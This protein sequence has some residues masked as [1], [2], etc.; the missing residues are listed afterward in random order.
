[1]ASYTAGQFIAA[2][3]GTGGIIS[4]IARRVGC[5]WHTAKRHIDNYATVAQV[6]D[7]ERQS[8][9]DLAEAK[10]IE[11][12]KDG[13]GPMIRF[14]LTMKGKDR[15]YVPR[16]EQE[17]TGKDGGPLEINTIEVIRPSG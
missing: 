15:S 13:D 5:D 6:Y 17:L 10:E 4:T 9:L 3:P 14:Y 7:D 12:I 8:V 1:M 16:V 11:A 2:I